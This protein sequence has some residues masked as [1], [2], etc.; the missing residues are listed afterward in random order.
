MTEFAFHQ[1]YI[2]SIIDNKKKQSTTLFNRLVLR[3]NQQHRQILNT[4]NNL[5]LQHSHQVLNQYQHDNSPHRLEFNK[6]QQQT[7]VT[8]SCHIFNSLIL[9]VIIPNNNKVST[10][11][12][13]LCCLFNKVVKF[14]N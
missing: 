10:Q 7:V 2:M 5:F 13:N 4:Y 12:S 1:V 3:V 11:F 14:V 9:V 6:R 8:F